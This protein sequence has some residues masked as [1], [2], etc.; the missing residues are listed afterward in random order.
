MVLYNEFKI[1]T[2]FKIFVHKNVIFSDAPE[3]FDKLRFYSLSFFNSMGCL[4]EVDFFVEFS[5]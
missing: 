4:R 1:T 3:N 5:A 2:F